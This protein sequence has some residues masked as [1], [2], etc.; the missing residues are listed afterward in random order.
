MFCKDGVLRTGCLSRIS[1]WYAVFT[2]AAEG[3]ASGPK[4]RAC[5]AACMSMAG[6]V[7]LK[8]ELVFLF[9]QSEGLGSVHGY[10]LF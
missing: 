10:V 2:S 6:E 9:S 7:L 3:V 1:L 5:K 8:C 4:P